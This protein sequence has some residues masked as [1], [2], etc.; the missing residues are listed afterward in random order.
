MHESS[1]RQ[2]V[3]EKYLQGLHHHEDGYSHGYVQSDDELKLLERSLAAVNERYVKSVDLV[4]AYIRRIRSAPI[5]NAVV[6]ERFE[7][8]SKMPRKSTDWSHREQ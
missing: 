5:I 2:N 6:E 4:S 1:D 7:E 8:L 3:I